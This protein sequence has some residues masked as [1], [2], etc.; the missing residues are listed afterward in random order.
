MKINIQDGKI[1]IKFPFDKEKIRTCKLIGMKWNKKHEYWWCEDR[2]MARQG[3]AK[4]FPDLLTVPEHAPK[5]LIIP[6]YLMDHQKSGLIEASKHDRWG[7]FHDTGVGKTWTALETFL[8]HKVKTLVICPLSL[9]EGAWMEEIRTRPQYKHIDISNLW[10]A[11]KGVNREEKLQEALQSDLCVVNY[12]LFRNIEELLRG[13]GFEMVIIDESSRIRNPKKGSTALKVIDFCDDVQYV[14]ELSGTP[15]PNN[16]L[17]YWSQIRIL[18][19]SLWGTSWYR[20]RQENF[21]KHGFKW[22]PH[23]GAEEKLRGDIKTVAEY[24]NKEDVL[25]L[26]G[27]TDSMRVFHLSPKEQQH[28]KEMK[29]QL[30]TI[31]D[32]GESIKAPNSLVA[33]GKM[34]QIPSGFVMDTEVEEVNEKIK[35]ITT[36]YPLGESKLKEY[37]ALLEDIGPKQVI[38]WTHFIEEAVMIEKA[39]KKAGQSCGILNGTVNETQKQKYL[40]DFKAGNLQHIICHPLSVGYGHTLINCSDAIYYGFS[41]SSGDMGQARDRIFRYGQNDIC[42]Y[43]YLVAANTMDLQVLK[44]VQK[45]QS[46]SSAILDYLKK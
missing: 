3:I 20:F 7:F 27:R 14:Y 12:E 46:A 13:V 24:V 40:R 41:Y 21:Y 31:L 26:P 11:W 34:R 32:S 42:S 2:H 4:A 18:D 15:A 8:H 17:E 36:V 25:D 10:A 45:K 22:L 28:Y 29:N 5:E 9:I 33:I 39:L 43:Y 23:R 1:H 19:P 44:A 16:L 37:M 35:R 6:G 30:I 38:T